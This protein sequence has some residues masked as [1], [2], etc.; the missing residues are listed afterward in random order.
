MTRHSHMRLSRLAGAW[1]LLA[2]FMALTAT[3]TSAQTT[4]ASLNGV[5]ADAQQGRLAGATVIARNQA[6]L[7]SR[8]ETTAADGRFVFSQLPPGQYEVTAELSG[9]RRFRQVD[10]P[11]R[12]NQAADLTI[13]L[14]VG[15]IEDEVKVVAPT[16]ALDTRSANQAVTF[17]GQ[18][19]SE[20]PQ[21][22]RTPFAAILGLAG[23]TTRIFGNPQNANQDQLF[24]GFGLNG[25]R[26]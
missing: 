3:T 23:T 17:T 24:N 11:L 7:E 16:V 18:M 25:G 1:A 5:V 9:F 2:G 22:T 6:T 20:L 13:V 15:G 14:D 12:A 21:G 19:V 10:L 8:E 4:T 26:D